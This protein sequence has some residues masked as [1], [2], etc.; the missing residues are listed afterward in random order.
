M[1]LGAGDGPGDGVLRSVHADTEFVFDEQADGCVAGPTG[2]IGSGIVARLDAGFHRIG[3]IKLPDGAGLLPDLE[4]GFD[5]VEGDRAREVRFSI[6]FETADDHDV[7]GSPDAAAPVVTLRV[8]A[9]FIGGDGGYPVR[10]IELG[11]VRELSGERVGLG[12]ISHAR[13]EC[14]VGGDGTDTVAFPLTIRVIIKTR[15]RIPQSFVDF[16]S[17]LVGVARPAC[18]FVLVSENVC[19]GGKVAGKE[20][21]LASGVDAAEH[22]LDARGIIHAGP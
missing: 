21:H 12:L 5:V 17:E 16:P 14:P 8:V 13:N 10:A 11:G 18:G 4:D 1:S 20:D 2:E 15:G 3:L 6:A 7:G 9:F 22:S 19:D